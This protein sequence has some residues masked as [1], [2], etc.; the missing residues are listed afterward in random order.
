MNPAIPASSTSDRQMGEAFSYMA[1]HVA[2]CAIFLLDTNGV[3]RTWSKA[4]QGLKGYE[5]GEA[6]GHF[7]GMLYT[8]E[9]QADG[10][11]HH[12]LAVAVERGTYQEERW[13]KKKDGSL[14]W[15]L[16][17]IIAIRGED[18]NLSGFCKVTR[19]I[20]ERKALQ[21]QLTTEKERAQLTLGAIGD[22]VISTD[23]MANITYLN[24]MAEQLTGWNMAQ[25]MGKPFA[26]VMHIVDEVTHKPLEH[27]LIAMA[28]EGIHSALMRPHY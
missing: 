4:S 28:T 8:E 19:D 23:N 7:F 18:G 21:D 25:P 27:Q 13:R 17:E 11:P 10:H 24:P 26:D 2:E 15:A 1:H 20:S 16:V 6:C 3:I 12:N 22:A 5:A 9:D 14:F